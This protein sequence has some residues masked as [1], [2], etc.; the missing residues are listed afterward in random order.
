MFYIIAII[1]LSKKHIVDDRHADTLQN[2]KTLNLKIQRSCNCLVEASS[3]ME[4]I[5]SNLSVNLRQS[6][7]K[8]PIGD[9][10]NGIQ[11]RFFDVNFQ[12]PFVSWLNNEKAPDSELQTLKFQPKQNLHCS[13]DFDEEAGEENFSKRKCDHR[14]TH[15]QRILPIWYASW[16]KVLH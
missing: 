15:G 9:P 14:R 10:V 2:L 12:L 7:S 13:G 3:T 8:S 11:W 6:L 16:A 4:S 1:G 5:F